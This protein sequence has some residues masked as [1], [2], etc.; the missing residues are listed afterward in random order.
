MLSCTVMS[1]GVSRHLLA[2]SQAGRLERVPNEEHQQR[3]LDMSRASDKIRELNDAFRTGQRTDLGVMVTTRGVKERG[4]AFL[5][6]SIALTRRF[7]TFTKDNDPRGEHDFGSFVLDGELVYWKIDYY[8]LAIEFGSPDP[9]DEAVTCR[10][11]TVFL[12]AEY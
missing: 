8:D 2:S 4:V 3:S 10:V 11:L 9:A 6:K 5:A 7:T 1:M 12:A